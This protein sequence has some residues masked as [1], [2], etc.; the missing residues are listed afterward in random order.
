VPFFSGRDAPGASAAAPPRRTKRCRHKGT[1]SKQQGCERQARQGAA[2]REL[3]SPDIAPLPHTPGGC[4]E[5]A[6][7]GGNEFIRKH[8]Q[9]QPRPDHRNGSH[10]RLH[11]PSPRAATGAGRTPSIRAKMTRA[12]AGIKT[13]HAMR[14]ALGPRSRSRPQ[15]PVGLGCVVVNSASA[16]Q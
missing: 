11:S 5:A 2:K 4:L 12:Q 14:Q 13:E 6:S 7:K 8:S 9:W 15:S 10:G 16:G 1:S 3:P